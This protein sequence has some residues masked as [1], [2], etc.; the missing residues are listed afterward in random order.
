M[1]VPHIPHKHVEV[2]DEDP[3]VIAMRNVRYVP[4]RQK[5]RSPARFFF[6][7]IVIVAA[8][9]VFWVLVQMYFA[10]A[11]LAERSHATYQRVVAGLFFL[12][13]IV[14]FVIEMGW[15][16]GSKDR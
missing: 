16:G 7:S 14:W 3:P 10:E 12:V 13:V 15:A 5:Q 6:S 4:S 11:L 9:A 1:T 2:T 8:V